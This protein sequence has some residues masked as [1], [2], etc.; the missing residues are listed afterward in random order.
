MD[1]IL[2]VVDR[3]SKSSHFLTLTY[4]FT[5]KGVAEKFVEGIIK[6]HGLPKSIISDRNP[7]FISRFW[8]DFF[9][10]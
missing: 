3:L 1:T 6:F 8:Q 7:V 10:M 9:Q 5:T 2:V 4:P